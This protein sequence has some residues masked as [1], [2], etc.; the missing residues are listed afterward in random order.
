MGEN[1][2]FADRTDEASGADGL[3]SPGVDQELVPSVEVV[4]PGCGGGIKQLSEIDHEK[5][6]RL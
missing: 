6:V 4:S 2:A 3:K 5:S 1:D